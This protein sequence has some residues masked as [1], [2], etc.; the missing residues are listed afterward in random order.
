MEW[1]EGDLLNGECVGVRTKAFKPLFISL[2][3]AME[4]P[5]L[6]I[7]RSEVERVVLMSSL[8]SFSRVPSAAVDE[9]VE[10]EHA[11]EGSDKPWV[12]LRPSMIYGP[13]NDRNISRLRTHL[14]RCGGGFLSSGVDMPHT[15]PYTSMWLGRRL[16]LLISLRLIPIAWCCW[17]R[18]TIAIYCTA[19]GDS[20]G[21]S[22]LCRCLRS[23]ISSACC[24]NGRS[25]ARRFLNKLRITGRQTHDIADAR[26]E[27]GFNPSAC[28]SDYMP[29]D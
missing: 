25:T 12:L 5:C 10:S 9:V 8:W 4:R 15:S 21:G 17:R 2:I 28:I 13:G 14:H 6:Q 1:V 7:C 16:P 18:A 29:P 24:A 19:L 11:V 27:T 26:R 3:F 22:P 23:Y 20:I